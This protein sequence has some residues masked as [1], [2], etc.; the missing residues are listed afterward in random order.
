MLCLITG[1]NRHIF[2]SSLSGGNKRVC[3]TRKVSTQEAEKCARVP[4]ID[5]SRQ[6]VK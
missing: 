6:G 2:F 5:A 4:A 1:Y 3:T